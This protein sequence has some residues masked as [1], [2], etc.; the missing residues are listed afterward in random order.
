[1]RL[2]S[3]HSPLLQKQGP[4]GGS[5]LLPETTFSQVLLLKGAAPRSPA[6]RRLQGASGSRRPNSPS[7][8]ARSTGDAAGG[9]PTEVL[10]STAEA[11]TLQGVFV[12]LQ[13]GPLGAQAKV[14][15]PRTVSPRL[16]G[17]RKETENEGHAREETAGTEGSARV[18]T[19]ASGRTFPPTSKGLREG[20]FM[21]KD[22]RRLHLPAPPPFSI[23]SLT[24]RT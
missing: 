16:L 23:S 1:M 5:D 12:P 15:L 17:G 13:E 14:E 20:A 22:G 2:R 7:A 24:A 19:R 11:A 3:T 9:S 21:N 10:A 4:P 6:R 18:A 8:G